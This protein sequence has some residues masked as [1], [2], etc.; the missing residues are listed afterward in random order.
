MKLVKAGR[1]S[2]AITKKMPC[3]SY[4]VMQAHSQTAPIGGGQNFLGGNNYW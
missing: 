4:G 1:P 2:N 3:R